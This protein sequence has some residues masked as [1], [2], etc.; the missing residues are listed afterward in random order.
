MS[1][2]TY[3]QFQLKATKPATSDDFGIVERSPTLDGKISNPSPRTFSNPRLYVNP[4]SPHDPY[5][6]KGEA[7]N[8]CLKCEK[9]A[10]DKYDDGY[11]KCLKVAKE[12]YLK[13]MQGG[14]GCVCQGYWMDQGDY[15][16]WTQKFKI[17]CDE[18]VNG[19]PTGSKVTIK[20][21]SGNFDLAW[22]DKE[23]CEEVL[24]TVAR[25][26]TTGTWCP[27]CPVQLLKYYTDIW[28]KYQSDEGIG[29][30]ADTTTSGTCGY[31]LEEEYQNEI[32]QDWAECILR[33]MFGKNCDEECPGGCGANCC[34][35]EGMP[36][37]VGS[38]GIGGPGGSGHGHDPDDPL[39]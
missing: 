9:T 28:E 1:K 32:V 6:V 39:H 8:P 2:F 3:L 23:G 14:G 33:I 12:K 17:H 16:G 19:I 22:V 24:Q 26:A 38:D 30:N 15:G 10:K 20:S 18:Y 27:S 31:E 34:E 13:D 25:V 11:K 36:P 5:T 4:K 21:E 29:P 35:G 7:T 37:S